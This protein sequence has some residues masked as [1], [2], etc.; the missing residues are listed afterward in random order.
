MQSLDLTNS[1]Q[2]INSRINALKTAN[3]TITSEKNLQRS[4]GNSFAQSQE[5][6]ASQLDKIKDFQKRYQ[7]E[8]PNSLDQLIG[9]IG[10][11]RGQGSETLKYLHWFGN[12]HKMDFVARRH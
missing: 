9:F 10:Q 12:K 1:E 7:R 11:T 2:R 4:L 5:K 3:E 8:P 6:I